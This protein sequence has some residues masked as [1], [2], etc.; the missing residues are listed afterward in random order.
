VLLGGDDLDALDGS[1]EHWLGTA[2]DD[3]Q[4][5]RQRYLATSVATAT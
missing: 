1:A 3:Y 4:Q 5:L 2:A